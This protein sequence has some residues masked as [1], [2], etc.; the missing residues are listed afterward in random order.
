VNCFDYQIPETLTVE[1]GDL[2]VVPFRRRRIVGVIK[3][4]SSASPFAERAASILHRYGNVRF[5]GSFLALLH[6][7]ATHTFCS[8]PT[9]L[10]AWLRTLP[11][12]AIL[13]SRDSS[14]PI[15]RDRQIET[16]WLT[17]P[18]TELC[19]RAEALRRQ[20]K[21]VL[22]LTPWKTRAERLHKI[23]KDSS[24]LSSEQSMG[25]YTRTWDTFSREQGVLI[26]TRIGAW[27]M[28]FADH[29]LLDEPENDDHKQDELSP[30]YDV[31]KLAAWMATTQ[32]LPLETFGITPALHVTAPIPTITPTIQTF[33]RH[34]G[35]HTD[36]PSLQADTLFAL[37]AHTGPRV[38]IHPIR[39]LL[40]HLTC[41]DCGWQP[42]C[43]TCQ[44]PVAL[45]VQGPICRLC[46]KT[47]AVSDTCPTCG[48][49]D[50][51]KSFP[52][53]ER[54]KQA[55]LRHYPDQELEWRDLS[56]EQLDAPFLPGS[57]VL[58]TMPSLLGGG[59]EDIRRHERQCVALR[60][61][62][63]RVAEAEGILGL[64]GQEEELTRWL[65]WLTEAG[66]NTL[67]AEERAARRLFQY[68]PSFRRIKI[69][70]DQEPT[71]AEAWQAQAAKTLPADYRWEGPFSAAYGTPGQRR[72]LI[73]HII[74]PPD[75]PES[76]LLPLL[77]PFAKVAKIDLDPI[78]FFK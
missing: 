60:R 42:I 16:R 20:G 5:P 51:G 8:E 25:D 33:L 23:I 49:A 21:R 76:T 12:R 39:G 57:F 50:F 78:A 34:P 41:R 24:L 27:L 65:S 69:L 63:A 62:A 43:E 38:V 66:V 55:W 73:W 30:R 9:V 48:N 17:N 22:I 10:H 7:T 14:A 36:I 45:D 70:V 77:N 71:A 32:N 61:L 35:G 37:E 29:V 67:F 53:I 31:R 19:I 18:E 54:L 4:L 56:N 47:V 6:W 59:S 52:G 64:Q 58:V 26:A 15:R 44:Y 13:E 74:V 68:P 40:A 46:K 2:V 11:K 3:T 28:P 75:V 72:R 1:V